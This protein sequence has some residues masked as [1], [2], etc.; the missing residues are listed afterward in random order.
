VLR[1]CERT[2]VDEHDLV[3]LDLDGVVYVGGEAVPHAPDAIRAAQRRTTVAYVT[4]NASR[5]PEDVAEHLVDLGVPAESADV[6]TS[7][8][9]AA[10]VLASRLA[11]GSPVAVLGARGLRTAVEQAGLVPVGIEDEARAVVTGYG[12]DVRWRDIMRAA[13]RIRTGTWWVA[14]NTD[15]SIPTP[16]GRA[17]G[18]GV[19]VDTL[20]RFSEVEPVVAGKPEPPLLEETVRR[21]G[22]QRPLMVGDRLDTDIE[23]AHRCGMASLL[24]R[25]GVSDLG[26]LL[27]APAQQRPTYLG[28]DLRALLEPHPAVTLDDGVA[29]CGGWTVR[30]ASGRLVVE[31]DGPD[32]DWWRAV[33]VAGWEH[34]DATG[35]VVGAPR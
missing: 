29:R 17:P 28:A 14:S 8:Q 15:M 24:V 31:G 23:G 1:S 13:V 5:R 30:V 3:M 21:V 34:L 20:R 19:L 2:L 32:D 18:H 10:S 26:D 6:V 35:E 27:A 7:A 22:G 16:E 25:T 9:A 33:A 11:E 12:P 4:N